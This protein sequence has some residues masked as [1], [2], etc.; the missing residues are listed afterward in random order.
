MKMIAILTYC[1]YICRNKIIFMRFFWS[2]FFFL[3]L[4]LVAAQNSETFFYDASLSHLHLQNK[5]ISVEEQEIEILKKD[6]SFL[7][8]FGKIIPILYRL[9][10]FDLIKVKEDGT[11][12]YH[13]KIAAP[14]ALALNLY[15]SKVQMDPS[16]K[17]F[18]FSPFENKISPSIE[19]SQ[20]LEDQTLITDHYNGDMLWIEY[21]HPPN[22]DFQN[23]FIVSGLTYCYKPVKAGNGFGDSDFC[24]VNVACSESSNYSNAVAAS[25]RIKV[26]NVDGTTAWCSGT[27]VNNTSNNG[28]PYILTANH[29][30]INSS[31]SKLNDWEF[32]F[33]YQQPTCQRTT[34]EPTLLVL[35]GADFIASP[36]TDDGE[37]SSD[38]L[39]LKLKN[40]ISK[41]WNVVFSGWNRT[42]A[43]TSSGVSIHHPFGDV[44]KISTYKNQ[45][46]S[47]QYG[48]VAGTHFRVLWSATQNGFSTTE[49]GSSGA[50]LFNANGHLI[51]ALTGGG[52][53]CQNNAL[54]D[55][56]G[57]FW[58]SWDRYGTISSQRLKDWLDPIQSNVTFLESIKHSDISSL[59]VVNPLNAFNIRFENGQLKIQSEVKDY[60]IQVYDLSG[61][62][63]YQNHA[64]FQFD[65]K[66]FSASNGVYL[67][68]IFTDNVLNTYK[69]QYTK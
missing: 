16:A 48:S 39:L 67:V 64:S 38:F 32:Y 60:N 18:I 49:G 12:I 26:I 27:L 31:I 19:A 35:K 46:T 63:L 45:P 22:S 41:N 52:A 37:F 47:V 21:H 58:F 7:Y 61:K 14:K 36:G 44:K 3:I 43:A 13:L 10:D 51:G 29:C 8:Q 30:R 68:K 42:G 5:I 66:D 28:T 9:E 53:S 69:V 15:F 57:R 6:T 62:I 50:G 2:F 40:S 17:I 56:Y 24:M 25:L 11:Q 34:I 23:P 55:F 4:K 59:N 54:P 65:S 1:Y 20:V 33:N